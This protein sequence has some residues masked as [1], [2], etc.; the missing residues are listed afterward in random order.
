MEYVIVLVC[1]TIIIT[2]EEFYFYFFGSEQ[3]EQTVEVGAW[4]GLDFQRLLNSFRHFH[5]DFA[6]QRT[7]I[8]GQGYPLKTAK[9]Q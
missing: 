5:H 3:I 2:R 7:T 6:K 8:K 4:F 1:C 9:H